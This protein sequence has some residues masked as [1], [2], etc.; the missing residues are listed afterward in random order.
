MTNSAEKDLCPSRSFLK[1]K[2]HGLSAM[3]SF[4]SAMNLRQ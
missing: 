1:H 4:H 3:L 2:K